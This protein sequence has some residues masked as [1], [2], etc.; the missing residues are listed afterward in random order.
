MDVLLLMPAT[1][2]GIIHKGNQPRCDDDTEMVSKVDSLSVLEIV[3][4]RQDQFD[5]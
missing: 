4:T 3:L 1:L 5:R 2:D